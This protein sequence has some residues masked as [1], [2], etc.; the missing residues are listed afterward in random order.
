MPF[1]RRLFRNAVVST[2]MDKTDGMMFGKVYKSGIF[3]KHLA[4]NYCAL[5]CRTHLSDAWYQLT[6]NTQLSFIYNF[7]LKYFKAL[8]KFFGVF[9][10][11]LKPIKF[12]AV[13]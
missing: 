3:G 12:N 8:T 13:L 1:I 10:S 11:H 2:G 4:H 6:F 5:K 9:C 7:A